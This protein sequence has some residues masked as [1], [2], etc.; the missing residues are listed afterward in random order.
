[1]LEVGSLLLLPLRATRPMSPAVRRWE[2]RA[3]L[4]RKERQEELVARTPRELTARTTRSKNFEQE[5]TA[6]S[7]QKRAANTHSKNRRSVVPAA[8][9]AEGEQRACASSVD[10]R[11]LESGIAMG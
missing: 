5:R 9:R 4:H 2:E 1:M 7:Q 3:T 8:G 10:G 6:N 11:V